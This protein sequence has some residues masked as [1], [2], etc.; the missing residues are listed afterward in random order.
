M[1]HRTDPTTWWRSG[2]NCQATSRIGTALAWASTRGI[3]SIYSTR[4][5]SR[6]IVYGREDVF[7]RSWGKAAR[8]A[9]G[10]GNGRPAPPLAPV[11]ATRQQ[12]IAE[13]ARRHQPHVQ[14]A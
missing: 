2:N 11:D 5:P 9:L 7:P 4:G 14:V 3:T 6:V 1:R 12:A 8:A 10:I 13:I